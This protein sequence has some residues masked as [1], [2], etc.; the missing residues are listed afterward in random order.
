MLGGPVADPKV[1]GL[2]F[3]AGTT[4]AA[5]QKEAA[6]QQQVREKVQQVVEQKKEEVKQVVEEKKEEAKQEVK[7]AE[8]QVK[9]QAKN[10]LKGLLR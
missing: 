8:E 2:A 6:P 5:Q 1:T 4:G 3:G 10:K 7:K 9:Q